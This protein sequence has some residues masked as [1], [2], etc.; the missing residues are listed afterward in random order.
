MIG[1]ILPP[2]QTHWSMSEYVVFRLI[3][4]YVPSTG[5]YTARILMPTRPLSS[6]GLTIGGKLSKMDNSF[7]SIAKRDHQKVDGPA[8]VR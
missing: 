4:P 8:L 1:G 3:S 6:P 7:V 5:I 2:N